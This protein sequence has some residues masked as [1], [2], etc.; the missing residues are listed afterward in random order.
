MG[1]AI[2]LLSGGLDS[3][4]ALYKAKADGFN[5]IYALT[6]I[7]GQ[8]HIKEIE[9]A[10][11]IALK[12]KVE[13]HKLV[14]LMLNDWGSSSLV[15]GE[16]ALDDSLIEG[17]SIPN[18]Y[19]PARNMVFL[20]VAA[21]YADAAGIR[22]IY[23]GVSEV[24]YSGY[25][26]CRREFIA[27]MEKAINMGTVLGAEKGEHIRIHTPF[28]SMKKSEEILLGMA[29]GVD[30]ADTWSCYKGDSLPCGRCESCRLRARAFRE[31]GIED[32]LIK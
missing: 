22:D 8:R 16:T 1:K 27:S 7:Y 5:R 2:V 25:V 10:R 23:I 11:K 28:M 17:T 19:V 24:D 18:T 20:S 29:L 30:Y 26:D 32:P 3:T 4:T 13:E 14:E 6:F 12:A 15:H 9:A 21:S 31:A